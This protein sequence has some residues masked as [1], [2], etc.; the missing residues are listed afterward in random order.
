V[1]VAPRGALILASVDLAST[2]QGVLRADFRGGIVS[3]SN[4]GTGSVIVSYG[5]DQA[6]PPPDPARL[7]EGVPSRSAILTPG[8]S[9]QLDSGEGKIA[10]VAAAT[11][12]LTFN[13]KE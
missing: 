9:I 2:P 12:Y 8:D 1:G 6:V 7:A 4:T 10:W 13:L 11:G 3:M 5:L